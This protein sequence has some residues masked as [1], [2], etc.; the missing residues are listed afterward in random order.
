MYIN[1]LINKS[2][3]KNYKLIDKYYKTHRNMHITCLNITKH[4]WVYIKLWLK[5]YATLN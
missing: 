4:T 3:L 2:H 5:T 1:F